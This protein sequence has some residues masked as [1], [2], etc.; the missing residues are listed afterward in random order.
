MDSFWMFGFLYMAFGIFLPPA[1]I[2]IIYIFLSR[3]KH[4]QLQCYRVMAQIGIVQLAA[5]PGSFACGLINI[6]GY[7]PHGILT[8]FVLLFSSSVAMEIFLSLVLALNR[9]EVITKIKCRGIVHKVVYFITYLYGFAYC[10]LCLSPL[11][12]YIVTPGH[13]LGSY[14][15]AK[16]YS[17]AFAK[18]NSYVL[19]SVSSITLLVYVVIIV[20]LTWRRTRAS[21]S[22]QR[23]MHILAYAGIRFFVDFGLSIFFFFTPITPSWYSELLT[24]SAYILNSLL[25]SP[26]LYLSLTRSI[27]LEFM[28][29][30]H[31]AQRTTSVSTIG[32]SSRGPQ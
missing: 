12:G 15:F 9:L 22:K 7:D 3:K 21:S 18:V 31:F 10:V 8:L 17:A 25:I 6:L 5:A 27:R 13:F 2:R 30:L 26:L 4:R 20:F 11:C 1:Y 32:Q 19:T 16:P 23:E 29:F 28:D 24:G 14:D